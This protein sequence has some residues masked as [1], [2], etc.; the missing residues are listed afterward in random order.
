M[1]ARLRLHVE[2]SREPGDLLRQR[3]AQNHGVAAYLLEGERSAGPADQEPADD[4]IGA[5]DRAGIRRSRRLRLDQRRAS[6]EKADVDV[7]VAGICANE[8]ERR[9]LDLMPV[10]AASTAAP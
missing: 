4:G 6:T 8:S 7:P 10:A 9:C 2:R 5:R 3:R 1:Q